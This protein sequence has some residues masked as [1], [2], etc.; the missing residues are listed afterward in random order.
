MSPTS[1]WYVLFKM[2]LR[3]TGLSLWH[4]TI[5]TPA[6]ILAVTVVHTVES[7]DSLALGEQCVEKNKTTL[8]PLARCTHFASNYIA[9]LVDETPGN[10]ILKNHYCHAI[11]QLEADSIKAADVK[12]AKPIKSFKMAPHY[13]LDISFPSCI[14]SKGRKKKVNFG[15][16][17]VKREMWL[18]DVSLVHCFH[19]IL[20]RKLISCPRTGI[21][22]LPTYVVYEKTWSRKP[23]FKIQVS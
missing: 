3:F 23:K 21:Y 19:C 1:I 5:Y 2:P 7:R 22:A 6:V 14:G 18:P 16:G 11:L 20:G 12:Q 4:R 10:N 9:R 8:F 15:S 13:F 17:N